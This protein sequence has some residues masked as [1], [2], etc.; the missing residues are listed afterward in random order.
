MNL[1]DFI[2]ETGPVKSVDLKVDRAEVK[3]LNDIDMNCSPYVRTV[4][5]ELTSR[6]VP[7]IRVDLTDV[8]HMDSSGLATLVEAL[9][10]V[11]RY[12]GNLV[13]FGLQQRVRSVFEIAKL[14]ELFT[15]EGGAATDHG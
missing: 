1:R 10:R 9:Q 7:M 4:M 11:K 2:N 13:I 12:N 14:T 6:K 5:V 3:L 8:P 15:I